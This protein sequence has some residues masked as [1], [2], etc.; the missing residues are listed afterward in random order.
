MLLADGPTGQDNANPDA[1]S[2][3]SLFYMALAVNT[4]AELDNGRPI[5]NPTEGALLMWLE[6][7]GQD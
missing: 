7:Q 2:R 3:N 1:E 5:G 4:T 6:Q